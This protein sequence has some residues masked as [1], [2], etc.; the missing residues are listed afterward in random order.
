[1][2]KL[3][4]LNVRNLDKE[5]LQ[6][7][8]AVLNK[9]RIY[10]LYIGS[11]LVTIIMLFQIVTGMLSQRAPLP[12]LIGLYGT[13]ALLFWIP[14]IRILYRD[15]IRKRCVTDGSVQGIPA[16]CISKKYLDHQKRNRCK[17][18]FT[19]AL[20]ETC[21]IEYRERIGDSIEA[22]DI[23]YIIRVTKRDI[24]LVKL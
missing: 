18:T 8:Q 9:K 5:E 23:F 1:M 7:L 11:I 3:Y 12:N 17:Y 20:G 14:S 13:I 16:R 22:N 21:S 10:I 6:R 15:V 2:N 19:T 24:F 4:K